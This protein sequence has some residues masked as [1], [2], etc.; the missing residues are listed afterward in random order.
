MSTQT[1]SELPVSSRRD[2]KVRRISSTAVIRAFPTKQ[3]RSQETHQKFLNAGLTLL[4][5]ASFDDIS[6]AQIASEAGCSVGSF[7]LRFRNKDAYFEFLIEEI[8]ETLKTT[9]RQQLTT[10]NIKGFSLAKTVRY[11][12]DHF[13]DINRQNEGLIR[14]ALIYSMNGSDDW[15]PIRDN[16]LML[17]AR[18]IDLIMTKV[19]RS[20][21]EATRERLM[22]GLQIMSSHLVNSIAHPVIAL[23]LQHPDLNHWMFEVVMQSLKVQV[24]SIPTSRRR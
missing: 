14:A 8:S 15:Q 18:Y 19:R 11:C 20:E 24:P 22:N 3:Q 10:E 4:H 13:I 1:L 23:P 5:A 16:G 7:Y 6:I 2:T 21:T 9:A 12:V 17:H